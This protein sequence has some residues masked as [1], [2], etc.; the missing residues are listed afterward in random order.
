MQHAHCAAVQ[1][2][3]W[4][5]KHKLTN[6]HAGGDGMGVDDEVRNNAILCPGHVFLVVGNADGPLLPVPTGK[7]VTHLGYPD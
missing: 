7:L 6:G 2:E 3:S 1:T 5:T 4:P